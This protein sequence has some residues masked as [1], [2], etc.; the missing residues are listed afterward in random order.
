ME[1]ER[2]FPYNDEYMTFDCARGQYV[3]TEK[4]LTENGIDLRADLSATSA[5]TPEAVVFMVVKTASDMIYGYIHKFSADND[6]QDRLIA[7][8]PPLRRII[9]E[10][11]LYQAVYIRR[12]GNLYLSTDDNERKK[13]IDELAKGWLERTVP[14]LGTSILYTGGY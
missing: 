1:N 3:L 13:A 6:L 14:G 7:T 9:F 2:N 8:H 11:M 12:V 10:A 4:A 5:V